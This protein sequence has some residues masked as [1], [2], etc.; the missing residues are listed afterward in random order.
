MKSDTDIE[1]S[2]EYSRCKRLAK[3][4]RVPPPNRKMFTSPYNMLLYLPVYFLKTLIKL[5]EQEDNEK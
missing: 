3:D 1:V 5:R 4:L 2:Q